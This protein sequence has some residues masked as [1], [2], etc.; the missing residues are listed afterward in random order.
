MVLL[1]C[2]R[3]KI[4]VYIH[5]LVFLY[6]YQVTMQGPDIRLKINF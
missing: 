1:R 3:L 6:M 4:H 5:R 2:L